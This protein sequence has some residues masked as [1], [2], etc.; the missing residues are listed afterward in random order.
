MSSLET[1]KAAAL[2][3]EHV[4]QGKGSIKNLCYGNKDRSINKKMLYALVCECCKSFFALKNTVLSVNSVDEKN[5]IV[6]MI[7]L[8][9]FVNGSFRY[10]LND[11]NVQAFWKAKDK[12]KSEFEVMKKKF[13][14]FKDAHEKFKYMRINRLVDADELPEHF[15][16]VK[17]EKQLKENTFMFDKHV[18]DLLVLSPSCNITN[19]PGYRNGALVSQDK[20][21]CIPAIVLAP[22]PGAHVIDGCAAPGNKTTQLACMV[23]NEGRVFAI[24]RDQERFETLKQMVKKANAQSIVECHNRDFLSLDPSL[25]KYADVRY[26]LVDPSCSGSGMPLSLERYVSRSEEHDKARL[27]QLA[28][29]QT[30]AIKQAMS[31]PKVERVVYSTCSVHERENEMVVEEVL[32]S[33]SEWKLATKPLPEWPRRGLSKYKFAD[34]L[35]RSDRTDHTIGFFVALFIRQ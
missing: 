2:I 28:K 26:A 6:W 29:F 16:Q 10:D 27:E 25:P 33:M 30:M 32:Q 3:I 20:A 9:E 34:N 23:G 5:V 21:S 7:L 31:F 17:S 19:L 35:I 24:E 22:P 14:P 1:V 11:K 4:Q 13:P 8:L 15:E 18:K 12:L